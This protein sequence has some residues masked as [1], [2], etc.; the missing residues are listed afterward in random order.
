MVDE[1]A[2]VVVAAS[3]DAPAWLVLTDTWFPGWRARVDGADV[4]VRRADHAFRAVALPPGRHEVEFTFTPRGLRAGAA[5]TLAAL[6]L[7]GVLL[8]P[9][10]R[11]ALTIAVAALLLA[12]ARTEAALPAP[13]FALTSTP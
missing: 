3:T 10:R 13:P 6:A 7:V 12:S 11:A 1:P 2:R 8:L 4:V 9:R 5:I